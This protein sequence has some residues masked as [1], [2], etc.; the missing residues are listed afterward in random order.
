MRKDATFGGGRP[1]R[2]GAG[3][4]S[5]PQI[6]AAA[7]RP[8]AI[9]KPVILD[10]KS[11]TIV[12]IAAANFRL[13]GEEPDEFT[14]LGQDNSPSL[15]RRGRPGISAVA[16]LR[17]GT[18]LKG[19]TR[20]TGI[21]CTSP[22]RTIPGLECSSFAA[23][24]LRPEVGDV[25]PTLWLLLG[26][27][28]LV[29]LIACANVASLMLARAISRQRELAMRVALG[30][31]RIR[32]VRQGLTESAVLSGF[33]G[34][35]GVLIAG[36]GVRPF[37]AF[38]PGSLPRAEEIQLD[39][40]VLAFAVGISLL[41]GLLFGLAPALRA[42]TKNVEQ[43]LRVGA[44]SL[45]GSSRRLH[46]GFVSAEIALAV[47]L[48]VAGVLDH[49]AGAGNW[50]AH[51]AGSGHVGGDMAGV[52]DESGNDFWGRGSGRCRSVGSRTRVAAPGRRHVNREIDEELEAHVA[53]A[54][55]S[56]RD[57]EQARRALGSTLR[58]RQ[59]SRDARLLTWLENVMQDVRY[60]LRTLWKSKGFSAV[61]ILTLALGI[62]ASTAIFSVIDNVLLAPFPYKDAGRLVYMSIHD[63]QGN[64][65]GGR[66][67]YSSSEYLDYAE[68][69]HVFD[70]VIAAAEEQ[71]LYK[72]GEGT[73]RLYGAHVTPGTF[74]FLGMPPLYGRVPEPADYEPGAPPV[75]VMRYKTWINQ[76]NGDLRVLNETFVLNGASRTLIGIMP[77]RF[78]WY[79][80]DVMIPDKPVRG[81]RSVG[82]GFQLGYWFLLGHLKPGV[83]TARG[84]GGLDG[85]C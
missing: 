8:A 69:N 84:T 75:F 41:S 37:V 50:R 21:D 6:L 60:A 80:A 23:D 26:A 79:E 18:T 44:R 32:L 61:T 54:M 81:A 77:P 35:L 9:G 57:A 15:Q 30:A 3:D 83:D 19:G 72:H 46:C 71:V 22:S 31:G 58:H 76:F 82:P 53:E 45:L 78:G 14:P 70:R 4:N 25:G 56:G 62:G 42:P 1:A 65:P 73:E 5:R 13:D 66:A 2:R 68:Q 12:G 17:P 7:I 59:E 29:L 63:T 27:V 85:D 64:E 38:W 33:G 16:R 11:F 20:G 43:I 48:L 55:A 40:R 24:P 47:V 34:T 67:G 28:S 36:L 51:D 52:E 49:T 74:E 39:W 10:G